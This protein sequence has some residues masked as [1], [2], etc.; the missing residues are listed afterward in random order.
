MP[1]TTTNGV[2]HTHTPLGR[3]SMVDISTVGI[4]SVGVKKVSVGNISQI[5][6][7]RRSTSIVRYWHPLGCRRAI[8][9]GKTPHQG[10]V[11]FFPFILHIPG[12]YVFYMCTRYF[13][14]TGK[15]S[16]CHDAIILRNKNARTHIR[17]KLDI[18]SYTLFH[19]TAIIHIHAPG[20]CI[21]IEC[22]YVTTSIIIVHIY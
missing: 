17:K 5:A 12:I 9:L 14:S 3:F 10:C 1:F 20:T 22:R 6:F 21:R 2:Y 15:K 4:H 16:W 11:I 19:F 7:R 18:M 13:T 8:E